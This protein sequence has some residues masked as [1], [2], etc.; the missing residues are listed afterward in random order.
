MLYL[1][2]ASGGG[3]IPRVEVRLVDTFY[4]ALLWLNNGGD[5]GDDKE[6]YEV[7]IEAE[8]GTRLPVDLGSADSIDGF[9]MENHI[10]SW[11]T[12]KDYCHLYTEYRDNDGLVRAS[13]FFGTKIDY[14]VKCVGDSQHGEYTAALKVKRRHMIL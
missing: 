6:I 7:E 2:Y 12:S 4:E 1:A 3:C 8:K 9:Y 10:K 11:L 14:F 13:G 5:S